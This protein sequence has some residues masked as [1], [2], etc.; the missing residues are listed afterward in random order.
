ME[1]PVAVKGDG[2]DGGV[3]DGAD[4]VDRAAHDHVGWLRLY[5]VAVCNCI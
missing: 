2:G 1:A 4:G 5:V 3:G